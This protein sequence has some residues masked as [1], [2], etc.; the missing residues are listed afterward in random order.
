MVPFCVYIPGVVVFMLAIQFILPDGPMPTWER[1]IVEQKE[2]EVLFGSK[3]NT[4]YFEK[5]EG[6]YRR[7]VS[8]AKGQLQTEGQTEL[9]VDRY[10]VRVLFRVKFIKASLERPRV[11][12]NNL[13]HYNTRATWP[14]KEIPDILLNSSCFIEGRSQDGIYFI[15]SMKLYCIKMAVCYKSY[16]KYF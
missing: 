6:A 1:V 7:L 5:L 11:V 2:D 15:P 12:L 4:A 10:C 14:A 9:L 8:K 13:L 3:H 16:T